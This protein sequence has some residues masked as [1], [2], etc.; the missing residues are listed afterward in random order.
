MKQRGFQMRTSCGFA[1]RLFQL[2][3]GSCLRN[4]SLE[5]RFALSCALPIDA[6]IHP[7]MSCGMRVSII[8]KCS[9]SSVC[10][11]NQPTKLTLH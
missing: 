1:A 11:T 9:L 6:P 10:K 8:L 4:C 5:K 3:S 2:G 7:T